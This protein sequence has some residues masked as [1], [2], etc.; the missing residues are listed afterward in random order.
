MADST[1]ELDTAAEKAE[2]LVKRMS[3]GATLSDQASEK[4]VTKDDKV[5]KIAT[6]SLQK[7]LK[8]PD[9]AT[10]F[11]ERGGLESLC[12]I[13]KKS[14]GNTLAYALNSFTSL[15][16]HNTGWESLND[17]FVA[18]IAHIV[19]SETLVTICRPATAILI[20]ILCGEESLFPSVTCLGYPTLRKAMDREPELL[21]TLVQRLQSPDYTLCLNSLSLLTA[22]L[23]HVTEEYQ[24]ELP[25]EIYELNAYKHI[26]RLMNN[27]PSEELKE[28]VLEFQSALIQNAN[29]R[30][31]T[32]ISL[33]NSRHAKMLNEIWEAA[34]VANIVIPGLRKWKKI[35]FSSEVPQR[36]F[37]RTGLFGLQRMHAFVMKNRDSFAKLTLEQ[38]HRPENKRCPFA[39]ASIEVT[40]VL[41]S[42]WNINAGYIAAEFEPLFFQFDHVHNTTMQCFYRIFQDMEATSTDFSKVSALIRSQ[43]RAVL[44]SDGIKDIYEFDH[45]MN[46]TPYQVIRDRR[47]RELEWAD[48]LLGREAIRNL[49]ARLNKQSYE[50][51]KK[52]RI[53]CLLEG[54]WFPTPISSQRTIAASSSSGNTTPAHPH[55]VSGTGAVSTLG[56]MTP[57][58]GQSSSISSSHRRW[59]YYKLSPSKKA[60]QYGDF[61]EKIANVINSYD[62]LPHKIDLN[63]VSEIRNL[64]KP[65]NAATMNHP[66]LSMNTL[67]PAS[68]VHLP[69][70][71]SHGLAF[72]LYSK[73]NTPL[74][75]FHCSSTTQL[76]EW[77]DG[78]SMLLDKGIT[79]KDTA[80]YLHSLTEIGVKVKLLQIAGDR[81]EI[82]HGTLDVPPVPFGLGTGFFYDID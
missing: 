27:H 68:A 8:E 56:I 59:R 52:Q 72:A 35:G 67:S 30:R 57:N 51:I 79:S 64:R 7:Y 47:L 6:F 76:S 16:E 9:F 53:S 82:P 3:A 31:S 39:K 19:V 14:S 46:G 38:I 40:D 33:H 62:Q 13:I 36:E 28:K 34:N 71:E 12:E 80:E 25:N 21:A 22:M 66:N 5:L 81:V 65:S 44:K 78:F 29:R 50:F 49:R 73:D 48:D 69:L 18:D 32:P 58:I 77:K 37:G 41:C 11:L 75:E 55:S 20:K 42:H 2:K 4:S 43:I 74:A 63:T 45:V 24:S 17:D 70:T 10:E 61:S 1:N 26:L 23:K 15:M 60:L 54:A